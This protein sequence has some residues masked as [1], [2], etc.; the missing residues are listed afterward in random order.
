MYLATATHKKSFLFL[1]FICAIESF[2]CII[3]PTFKITDKNGYEFD[4]IPNEDGSY[5]IIIVGVEHRWIAQDENEVWVN[6]DFETQL[7]LVHEYDELVNDLGVQI[8]S[9]YHYKNE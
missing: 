5:L 4:V 2:I 9:Y 6:V 8:E 1:T 3:D 7:P